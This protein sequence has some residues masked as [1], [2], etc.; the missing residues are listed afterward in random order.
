MMVIVF[1]NYRWEMAVSVIFYQQKKYLA[2]PPSAYPSR[3][4]CFLYLLVAISFKRFGPFK[5][6]W[7]RPSNSDDL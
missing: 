6:Y 5:I 1:W 2:I 7:W 3:L 4:G